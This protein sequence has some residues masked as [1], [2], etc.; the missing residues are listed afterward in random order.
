MQIAVF[1]DYRVGVVQA[2]SVIDVTNVLPAALDSRPRDRMNWLIEGWASYVEEVADVVRRAQNGI[3]LTDVTL[4]AANPAPGQLFALPSNFHA[5]LG[6]LGAR[7]VTKGGRTARE[8]GFFLKAASSVVGAGEQI[9]LPKGSSRRFDH[10]CELAV[11]IGKTARDVPRANAHEYVFGCSGLIDITMRLEPGEFEEERS[12]RK[13]FETF[14]PLGPFVVTADELGDPSTLSAELRVNDQIRQRAAFADMIV[15]I[16][17]AI[18]LI[19]SVTTLAPG[20]VIAM[21]TPSGVGPLAAGDQVT[22]EVERIGVM[23][24]PV[25]ER[26]LRAP[27]SY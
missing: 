5:H 12:M 19:S 26:A 23:S 15:D 14:T 7:T 25:A 27:R 17:E 24:L 10:E 13:S 9:T 16:D 6:E 18:E 8:Q 3:P 4:R 20:D 1:D 22:I 2:D 21:G 11:I